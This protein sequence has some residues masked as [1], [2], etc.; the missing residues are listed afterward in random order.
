MPQIIFWCDCTHFSLPC[1]FTFFCYSWR[2]KKEKCRTKKYRLDSYSFDTDVRQA[3][4]NTW[5]TTASKVAQEQ[6]YKRY[7]NQR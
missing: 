1:A 5:Q 3:L 4:Y 7:M 6:S 2:L